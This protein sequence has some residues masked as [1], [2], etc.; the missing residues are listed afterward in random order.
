MFNAS[1]FANLQGHLYIV[2]NR[3]VG[4]T[5]EYPQYKRCIKVTSYVTIEWRLQHRVGENDGM[6]ETSLVQSTIFYIKSIFV[7]VLLSY[8]LVVDLFI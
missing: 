1:S 8:Q 3:Y 5:L 2:A 4:G 6:W 7:F